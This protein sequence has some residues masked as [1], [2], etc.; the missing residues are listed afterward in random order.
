VASALGKKYVRM[1]T[2]NG[3]LFTETSKAGVNSSSI[4]EVIKEKGK[5]NTFNILIRVNEQT[6]YR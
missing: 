3:T 1:A 6:N 2:E 5:G 4:I